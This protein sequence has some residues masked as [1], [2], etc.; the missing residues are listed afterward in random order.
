MRWKNWGEQVKLIWQAVQCPEIGEK[1]K[2]SR[3]SHCEEG[4]EVAIR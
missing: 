4:Y 2:G 3:R 1:S